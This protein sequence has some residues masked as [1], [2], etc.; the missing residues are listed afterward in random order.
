MQR[1]IAV[2][3]HLSQIKRIDMVL[4]RL[5]LRHQLHLH[6]P[7][8]IVATLDGL[9]EIPLVR[10]TILGN[11]SL[12]LRIGHILDSL[13]RVQMKLHPSAAIVGVDKAIC[14]AAEAVHMAE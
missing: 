14:V 10:L 12:S 6:Q 13:Q 4:A 3:P 8:R 1:E 5:P 2:I 7:A 9:E 11:H